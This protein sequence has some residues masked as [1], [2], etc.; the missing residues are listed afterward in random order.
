MKTFFLVLCLFANSVWAEGDGGYIPQPPPPHR[1]ER[2]QFQ[3]TLLL[4][5]ATF[6]R[7]QISLLNL[8]NLIPRATLY[9]GNDVNVAYRMD[10]RREGA[11]VSISIEGSGEEMLR[12]FDSFLNHIC[13]L[14]FI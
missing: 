11:L 13:C 7:R 9:A 3:T 4:D 10:R 12:F 5:R 1:Q 8:N 2:F 6:G 14:W